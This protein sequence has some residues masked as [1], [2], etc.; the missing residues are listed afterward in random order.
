MSDEVNAVGPILGM[1]GV[2]VVVVFV[3]GFFKLDKR[4]A[5]W[6]VACARRL[7]GLTGPFS[8][9]LSAGAALCFGILLAAGMTLTKELGHWAWSL[10]LM[11][12]QTLV[13]APFMVTTVPTQAGYFTWRDTLRHAGADPRQ[14]RQIAWWAGPPSI[15]GMSIAIGVW[16][17]M[18]FTS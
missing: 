15:A 7:G 5:S 3:S 10:C 1:V 4:L 11:L 17:A 18:I 14:Q 16:L 9:V 13:Y 8:F 6:W 2:V 12:P